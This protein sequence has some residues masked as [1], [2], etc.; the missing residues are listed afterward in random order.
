MPQI[1]VQTGFRNTRTARILS[2]GLW[3]GLA[4]VLVISLILGLSQLGHL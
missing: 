2:Y 3:T 4:A 1:Q